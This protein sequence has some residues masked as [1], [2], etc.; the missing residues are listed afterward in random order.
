MYFV[1]DPFC[2]DNFYPRFHNILEEALNSNY[3]LHIY[4]TVFPGF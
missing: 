2:K 1:L 3:Q 4:L